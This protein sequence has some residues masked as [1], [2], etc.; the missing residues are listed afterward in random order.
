MNGDSR[1]VRPGEEIG[2]EEEFEAGIGTFVEDGRILASIAGQ[3]K[4]NGR[5]LEVI[6]NPALTPFAPGTWIIGY[7]DNIAEPVALIVAQ[8]DE[9][10]VNKA[11]NAN[12]AA[13]SKSKRHPKSSTYVILHAS[14]IKRG[15]VKNVR[16]EYRIGDIIR[17]RIIGQKNDEYHASTD[18]PHAGCLIAFCRYCRTPME[19]RPSGLQCPECERRDNRHIADDYRV[20]A[21]K[22]TEV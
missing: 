13:I 16:D 20:I 15:Y 6:G 19:K 5:K 8:A 22:T 10:E 12:A 3:L 1:F 9:D 2:V 17:A 21:R 4:I 14:Y 18:D 11:L 7:I